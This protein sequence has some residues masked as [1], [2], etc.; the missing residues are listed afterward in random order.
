MLGVSLFEDNVF[1]ISVE[2]ISQVQ[3]HDVPNIELGGKGEGHTCWS[4]V[5]RS[6]GL[7]LLL[8]RPFLLAK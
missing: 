2:I 4:L 1:G 6:G 8:A 5:L 7:C 3:I